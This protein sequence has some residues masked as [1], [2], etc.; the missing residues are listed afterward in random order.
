MRLIQTFAFALLLNSGKSQVSQN[1]EFKQSK[2]KW[3][4]PI[5]NFS[6]F[7]N[8]K[9]RV[10]AS[11]FEIPHKGLSIVPGQNDSVKSVFKGKVISVFRFSNVFAVMIN[12]GD[13]FITY[14]YLDNP[15]VKKGDQVKEGEFL[16]LLSS[17]YRQLELMLTDRRDKEFDPYEWIKW[18]TVKNGQN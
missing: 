13:Y 7:I 3:P 2:G 6:K 8:F 10:S 12:Y 1:T 14:A 15:V 4:P 16:G 11:Y 9:E 18:P 17:P 5:S